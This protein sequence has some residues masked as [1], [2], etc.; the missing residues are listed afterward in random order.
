MVNRQVLILVAAVGSEMDAEQAPWILSVQKEIRVQCKHGSTMSADTSGGIP[1]NDV[2][3]DGCTTAAL[4]IGPCGMREEHRL[5]SCD[6]SGRSYTVVDDEIK[7]LREEL[8][9]LMRATG[10]ATAEELNRL[11]HLPLERLLN[12]TSSSKNGGQVKPISIKKIVP[13]AFSGFLHRPSF[14]ETSPE[15]RAT[16]TLWRSLHKRTYPQNSTF[17]DPMIRDGRAVQ[18]AR[19]GKANLEEEGSK[20]IKTDSEHCV[21]DLNSQD[22]SKRERPTSLYNSY[23]VQQNT[24]L[25]V[26]LAPV[27]Q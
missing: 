4:S 26:P 10:V 16:E 17:P 20:W 11:H 1:W 14:R 2:L 21:R 15:W 9:L 22:G 24:L 23:M 7:R 6:G 12:C 13:S 19:K 5:K 3:D 27:L 18:M 8:T 25:D